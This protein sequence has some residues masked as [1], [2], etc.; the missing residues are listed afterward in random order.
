[1]LQQQLQATVQQAQQA[2]AD[3]AAQWQSLSDGSVAE[4]QQLVVGHCS[5]SETCL[6]SHVPD[7]VAASLAGCG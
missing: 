2:S 3:A 4:R 5:F 1:M 6:H 7:A